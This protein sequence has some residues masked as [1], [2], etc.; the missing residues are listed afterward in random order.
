MEAAFI[1]SEELWS[2]GFGGTHPLKP[3]RL[4]RTYELG[5]HVRASLRTT[6]LNGGTTENRIQGKCQLVARAIVSVGLK[7]TAAALQYSP[8]QIHPS[9]EQFLSVVYHDFGYRV[10]PS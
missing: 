8:A 1:C 7:P 3:E 6:T 2:R 5:V 9:L 10:N 4:K